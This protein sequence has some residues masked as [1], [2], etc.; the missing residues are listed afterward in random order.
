VTISFYLQIVLIPEVGRK[1]EG[2]V[3]AT[4]RNTAVLSLAIAIA[5]PVG[6]RQQGYSLQQG[7]VLGRFMIGLSTSMWCLLITRLGPDRLASK[8]I[9]YPIVFC[10]IRL[11]VRGSHQIGVDQTCAP[12]QR[13]TTVAG[14]IF[15][16]FCYGAFLLIITSGLPT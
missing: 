5:L 1:E 9:I 7:Y 13:E 10:P 6:Q 2:L 8:F 14:P 15:Y 4:Y 12:F 11:M 16:C 3:K